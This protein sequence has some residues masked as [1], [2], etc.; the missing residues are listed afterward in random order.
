MRRKR[1]FVLIDLFIRLF[2]EK[3]LGFLGLVIIMLLVLTAIFADLTWL[4]FPPPEE[5]GP[6]LASYGWNQIMLEQRLSPPSPQFLLGTDNLGRDILSRLLHGVR[7]ELQA[8]LTAVGIFAVIAVGWA[9]LA[10]Y[11]RKADSWLGDTLEDLVMLPRDVLCAFPWLVMLIFVVRRS[12]VSLFLS[13]I[14]KAAS[15]SI[16]WV[17]WAL[18]I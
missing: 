14:L 18:A 8:G 13:M 16:I 7:V 10:A 15:L 11:L 5:G 1:R 12:V 6:G 3:P 17:I 9:M 2:K 4:G